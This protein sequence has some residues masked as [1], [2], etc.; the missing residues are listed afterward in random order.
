MKLILAVQKINLQPTR[1]NYSWCAFS[2][3]DISFPTIWH[4]ENFHPKSFLSLALW[5]FIPFT[6]YYLLYNDGQR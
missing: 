2:R 6:E 3:R 5:K 4:L 1:H